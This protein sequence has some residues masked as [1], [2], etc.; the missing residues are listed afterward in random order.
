[1]EQLQVL[2][3]FPSVFTNP[4]N[5]EDRCFTEHVRDREYST[6]LPLTKPKDISKSQQMG[7][8]IVSDRSALN[9]SCLSAYSKSLITEQNTLSYIGDQ[10]EE[11]EE[12]QRL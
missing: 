4:L 5:E 10:D 3:N 9:K 7:S 2:P 1:M 12:S 11:D 8:S 6:Q